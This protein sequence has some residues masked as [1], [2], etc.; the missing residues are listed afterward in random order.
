[1]FSAALF[2]GGAVQYAVDCV[3]ELFTLKGFFEKGPD[4]EGAQLALVHE[5]DVD[6]VDRCRRC[7]RA[8]GGRP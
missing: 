8:P 4:A 1:M 6:R 3:E 5:P 2:S 7:G